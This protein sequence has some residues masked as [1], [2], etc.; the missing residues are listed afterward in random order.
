MSWL[1]H[2][3]CPYL[4]QGN[5]KGGRGPLKGQIFKRKYEKELEFPDYCG[6]QKKK[7]PLEQGLHDSKGMLG[8]GGKTDC[9]SKARGRDLD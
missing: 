2:N 8:G 7:S 5:S 6:E 9:N 4:P 1:G 3:L